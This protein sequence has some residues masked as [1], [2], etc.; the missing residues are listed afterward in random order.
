[1]AEYRER[2]KEKCYQIGKA[3]Q[4]SYEKLSDFNKERFRCAVQEQERHLEEVAKDPE[5]IPQFVNTAQFWTPERILDYSSTVFEGVDNYYLC[6]N[7]DCRAFMPN[8]AWLIEFRALTEGWVPTVDVGVPGM[9]QPVKAITDGFV[10]VSPPVS[11]DLGHYRCPCCFEEYQP[12]KDKSHRIRPNKLLVTSPNGD[13]ELANRMRMGVDESRVHFLKWTTTA[14][15]ILERRF[16]EIALDLCEETKNMNF[17]AL[18]KHCIAK[19]DQRSSRVYFEKQTLSQ[20]IINRAN[21]MNAGLDGD[22]RRYRYNHLLNGF[23]CARAPPYVEGQSVV[24]TDDDVIRHF[25]YTKMLC[26]FGQQ[27]ALS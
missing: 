24:L 9:W 7:Q 23:L 12:W 16:Q 17:D 15:T 13:P 20:E 5:Y 26:G 19:I 10:D 25:A 6:R 14:Q 27:R 3:G 11:Y 22:K 18:M 21:R 1:M 8:T 4:H 2:L